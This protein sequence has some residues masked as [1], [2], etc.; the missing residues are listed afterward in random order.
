MGTEMKEDLDSLGKESSEDPE[1]LI[2]IQ[3]LLAAVRQLQKVPD[4]DMLERISEVIASIDEDSDGIVKMEHVNKVIEILGR[5][6]VEASGKQVKQ[7][8]DL[9][10]KEEL[11]EVESRIEKIVGKATDLTEG[12]VEPHIV[13]MFSRDNVA[14]GKEKEKTVTNQDNT[15]KDVTDSVKDKEEEP[16]KVP[17]K[18]GSRK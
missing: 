1:E 5:D 4:S 13:E 14:G 6:N 16:L 15:I 8:I 12:E 3:D 9:I 18:N 11:L 17:Q 10:V 2:T 7:I